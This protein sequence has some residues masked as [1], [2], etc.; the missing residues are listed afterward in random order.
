[1]RT[2]ELDDGGRHPGT[3]VAVT[4]GLSAVL[5]ALVLVQVWLLPAAVG[6]AVALFPEAAPLA[7][8]ALIWGV[9]AIACWQAIAVGGLRLVHLPRWPQAE[10]STR[11]WV[12]GVIGCLLAFVVLDG[13]AFA[14]LNEAGYTP[15]GLML[16][17]IASGLISLVAAAELAL[18]LASGHSLRVAIRR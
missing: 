11:Q 9:C 16:G 18:F 8:P 13:L 10:A 4:V 5:G 14:R 1:M 17:L 6:R 7:A 12:F 3:T 2:S 15:P